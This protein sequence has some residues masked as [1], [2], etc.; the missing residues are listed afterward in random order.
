MCGGGWCV[1][2][3]YPACCPGQPP[4]QTRNG[5]GRPPAWAPASAKCRDTVLPRASLPHSH[6]SSGVISGQGC[7]RDRRASSLSSHH[8]VVVPSGWGL[9]EET[10]LP[11]IGTFLER[12]PR[13]HTPFTT[14]SG[15]AG[16][17]LSARGTQ[18]QRWTPKGGVPEHL[19]RAELHFIPLCKQTSRSARQ[20]K[21][22]FHPF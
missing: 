11:P 22:S 15:T 2:I 10:C 5:W 6:C 16:G 9:W 1:P 8:A 20:R 12:H 17:L 18:A 21:T 13:L 19:D 7:V 14:P 3:P 4:A